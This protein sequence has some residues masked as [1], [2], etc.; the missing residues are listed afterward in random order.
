MS[1]QSRPLVWLSSVLASR[2]NA[3][4]AAIYLASLPFNGFAAFKNLCVGV[5]FV[6]ALRLWLASAEKRVPLTDAFLVWLAA[7]MAS[8]LWSHDVAASVGAIWRDVVKTFLVFFTFFVL[9]GRQMALSGVARVAIIG[10]SIFAVLA[11]YDFS[12]HGWWGNALTPARYDVSIDALNWLVFVGLIAL[13]MRSPGGQSRWPWFGLVALA[14]LLVAGVMSQ[15][16]SFNLSIAMAL[17]LMAVMN[18]RVIL[19]HKKTLAISVGAVALVFVLG[20]VLLDKPVSTYQDRWLLYSTV[21]R[22]ISGNPWLGTGFGHETD[23]AWY[24]ATFDHFPIPG[25]PSGLTHPHNVVL[26]YMDQMGIWGLL[27]LMYLFWSIVRELWPATRSS[28]SWRKLLGQAGMLLL[29][30]TLISNSFNFYFARQHLWMFF[31]MLGLLLGWARI[32]RRS[33]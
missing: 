9:A 18:P 27:V 16:R 33:A 20:V 21:W 1:G 12:Y 10:A 26:S 23:Q 30:M 15:S 32:D 7:A 11:I 28:D 24:R 6:G 25:A 19:R 3:M 17:L 8:L 29:L 14:L 2:A 22:K 13:A 4:A 5:A 31:G